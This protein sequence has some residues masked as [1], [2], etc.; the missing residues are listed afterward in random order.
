MVQKNGTNLLHTFFLAF[1]LLIVSY[2]YNISCARLGTVVSAT[3][4]NDSGKKD[5]VQCNEKNYT[6]EREDERVHHQD[7]NNL[8]GLIFDKPLKTSL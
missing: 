6:C 3:V 1:A 5:V 2:K 7:H 4:G 8:D